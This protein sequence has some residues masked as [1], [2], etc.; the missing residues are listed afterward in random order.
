MTE[1]VE[2]KKQTTEEI[3]NE[4]QNMPENWDGYGA[5][6]MNEDVYNNIHQYQL[7]YGYLKGLENSINSIH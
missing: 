1:K 4:L 5:K 6:P 2:N 3:I 7:H